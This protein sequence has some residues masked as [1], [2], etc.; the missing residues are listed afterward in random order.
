M[1][2]ISIA[3]TSS[4]TERS[5]RKAARNRSTLV[6]P[7]RTWKHLAEPHSPAILLRPN[8]LSA[9]LHVP[10]LRVPREIRRSRR[11]LHHILS[12]QE[13]PP[14]G[15]S[16]SIRQSRECH[17]RCILAPMQPLLPYQPACF[18]PIAS[19]YCGAHGGRYGRNLVEVS[20]ALS[21]LHQCRPWSPPNCL[22]RS[23]VARLCRLAR[24][25]RLVHRDRPEFPRAVRPRSLV[26]SHIYPTV[27]CRI[28]I[29]DAGGYPYDLCLYILRNLAD[30][31]EPVAARYQSIECTGCSNHQC[32]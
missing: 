8:H 9:P 6:P 7:V 15:S 24:F 23:C 29:L 21:G 5:F 10:E 30:L 14:F 31:L 3:A 26:Q 17:P 12:R 11:R 25:A 18:V 16:K 4:V 2:A 22:S 27:H 19:R 1:V 20:G 32:R 28:V 13:R